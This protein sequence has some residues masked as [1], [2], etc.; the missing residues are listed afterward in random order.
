MAVRGDE[1]GCL[2][3]NTPIIYAASTPLFTGQHFPERLETEGK[4]QNFSGINNNF[5]SFLSRNVSTH[6]AEG[7]HAPSTPG[8]RPDH[9]KTGAQEPIREKREKGK[10]IYLNDYFQS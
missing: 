1:M 4:V 6:F 5:S 10:I 7:I 8:K 2:F 9:S 3:A